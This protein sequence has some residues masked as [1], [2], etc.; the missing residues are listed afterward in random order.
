MGCCCVAAGDH[1]FADELGE[2]TG[3][4]VRPGQWKRKRRL[5]RNSGRRRIRAMGRAGGYRDCNYPAAQAYAARLI[6]CAVLGRRLAH[7]MLL[8]QWHMG[9]QGDH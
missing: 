1:A 6:E 7:Q 9:P 4:I 5:L 3:R 8:V 2:D